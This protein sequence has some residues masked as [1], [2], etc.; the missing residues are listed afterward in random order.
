MQFQDSKPTQWPPV[1]HT[2]LSHP[3]CSLAPRPLT[4]P[5]PAN[6][7]N[8]PTTRDGGERTNFM[9]QYDRRFT[10]SFH[11]GASNTVYQQRVPH[12][13]EAEPQI[14]GIQHHEHYREDD[15]ETEEDQEAE[16]AEMVEDEE[17]TEDGEEFGAAD[18]NPHPEFFNDAFDA[19]MYDRGLGDFHQ[20]D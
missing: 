5:Q 8:D 10:P 9:V 2:A 14:S 12:I 18:M 1:K 11:Y 17:E 6:L 16:E 15:E 3:D 7:M 4:V 20:N 13:Y 19:G